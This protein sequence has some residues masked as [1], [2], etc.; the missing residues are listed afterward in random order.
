MTRVWG[1][2][3][4]KAGLRLWDDSISPVAVIKIAQHNLFRPTSAI[5]ETGHQIAYMLN[6]NKELASAFRQEL[7]PFSSVAAEE[8]QG[9]ASEIAADAFAFVHTGYASI[10]A[11]HDVVGGDP[12]QVVRYNLGDPHPVSYIRLLLG[13]EMCRQ[14]FGYGPWEALESSWKKYYQVPP[15]GSHDASVI[16]ACIPLLSKATEILLKRRFRAFGN[17]ALIELIHPKRVRPEE[18]YRLEQVAGDALYTN[19]GWVWKECIRLMALGGLKVADAKPVEISKIYKQQEDWMLRLG[20][21][22]QI[23]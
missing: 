1:A 21:N 6:W 19:Q 14:F 18:L 16:K 5:H 11:L 13:I 22:T 10:I 4:L 12:Y 8:F 3:I 9:W 20:E 23:I 15:E 2:S 17:R 7:S